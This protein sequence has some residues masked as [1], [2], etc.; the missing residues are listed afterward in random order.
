MFRIVTDFV[1]APTLLL[2]CD[3]KRCGC[4]ATATLPAGSDE[5]ARNAAVEPF[6]VDATAKGWVIAIDQHLCPQHV[7]RIREG[8]KLV[9]VPTVRLH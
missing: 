1:E 8:R 3:D 6:I 2:V 9:M 4:F 7:N 5:Q